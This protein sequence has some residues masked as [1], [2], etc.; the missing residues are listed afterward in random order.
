MT[1][2]EAIERIDDILYSP[3][4]ICGYKI[5]L[6]NNGLLLETAKYALYRMIPIFVLIPGGWQ[7][8]R[9]TRYICPSCKKPTRDHEKFCHNCGQ[10]VKYPRLAYSKAENEYVFDWS[11][12]NEGTTV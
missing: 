4:F 2:K 3:D 8:F 6:K 7:G 12:G 11:E 5:T 1:P 9:R 10:A